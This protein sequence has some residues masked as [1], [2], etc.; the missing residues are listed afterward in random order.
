MAW[1][2]IIEPD[3]ATG[4]L[5]ELYDTIAEK[6]GKVSN[7]LKVHS[8]NPAALK[9]HLD[10]YDV[11]LFGYSPL[12]RSDREALAV[13]VS[14]ANDFLPRMHAPPADI[15]PEQQRSCALPWQ[16]LT[17][18]QIDQHGRPT[19]PEEPLRNRFAGGCDRLRMDIRRPRRRHR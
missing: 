1:I 3:D 13:V 9:E 14:A 11:I 5:K 17:I 8:Q 4:D 19:Q 2:D 10:L 6:R 15:K 7:V 12:S 18:R 16:T